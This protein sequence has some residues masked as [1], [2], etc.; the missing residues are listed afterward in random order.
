MGDEVAPAAGPKPRRRVL[1]RVLIGVGVTVGVL[2]AA[3]ALLY[4]FGGMQP[5]SAE[6]RASYDALVAAGLQPAVPARF[7]IPIPGCVCHGDDPV[8]Q[9]RHSTRRISEC[10]DC[11]TRG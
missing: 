10:F 4:V 3:S 6:A 7:T 2:A 1:R 11:H 9:V 5:P 8:L